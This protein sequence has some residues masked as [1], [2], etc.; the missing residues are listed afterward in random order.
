MTELEEYQD[1]NNSLD[2]VLQID[3]DSASAK[4]GVLATRGLL[5]PSG[6]LRSREPWPHELRL[7]S[8][9]WS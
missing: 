4:W 6:V 7:L 9:A 2:L 1:I 8:H 5:Q 3:G